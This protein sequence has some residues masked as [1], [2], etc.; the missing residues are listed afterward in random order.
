[1]R[2]R[3][4]GGGRAVVVLA[5]LT[6][7]GFGFGCRRALEPSGPNEGAPTALSPKPAASPPGASPPP[8]VGITWVDPPG[9]H[10]VPRTSPTQSASY[11]VPRAAGDVADGALAVFHFGP[12]QRSGIDATLDRWVEQFSGVAPGAVKRAFREANGLHLYTV[13]I[14]HGAFDAGPTSRGSSALKEDYALEGAIAEGPSGAYLFKMTGPAR[15]IAA[16]RPAFIQLI[17]SVHLVR[18]DH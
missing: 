14:R 4:V 11:V 2:G 8:R 9:L 5:S 13:E 12:E 17:D 18:A 15:T 7:L 1:M 16:G 6:S 3:F 10:R